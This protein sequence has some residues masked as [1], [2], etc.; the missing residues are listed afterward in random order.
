MTNTAHNP[1]AHYTPDSLSINYCLPI[2]SNQIFNCL[3]MLTGLFFL[4]RAEPVWV[5]NLIQ[6]LRFDLAMEATII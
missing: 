5:P 2:Y 6:N 4:I 3:E 1:L